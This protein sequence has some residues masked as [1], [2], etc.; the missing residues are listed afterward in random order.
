MT[1]IT[2]TYS[3]EDNKI[4]LYPASRLDAETYARVKAA[5]FSWAPKQNLFVAPK[6]TT[7]REDLALELAGEIEPEEMTIAER[8][9]AKA[10]RLDTLAE[11]RRRDASAFSRAADR[12]SERFY[13]GQ[14]ILVGHHSERSARRDQKRMHSAMDAAN[15]AQKAVGYWLYKASS[16]EQHANYKKKP[17][18]RARRIETLLAE[19]RDLQRDINRA[20]RALA[21]WEKC[22]TDEQ[23]RFALGRMDSRETCSGWDLYSAVDKGETTPADARLQCIATAERI[24]HGDIMRRWIEH[25]LNRLSFEREMLGPVPR[26]N[27]KLTPVILQAFART[28]G[29]EKPEACELADGLSW[30]ISSPVQLPLHIGTGSLVEMTGDEWRDLMQSTGYEVPTPVERRKSDKPA[31]APLINPTPEEAERLQAVW[32]LRA[33]AIFRKKGLPPKVAPVR[34]VT[35]AAYSNLSKGDY[36]PFKTVE[37]SADGRVIQERWQNMKLVKSGEP[38]ARI[39][40]RR[41]S[42]FYVAD[43]VAVIEDKPGKP[44]PIDLAGIEAEARAALVEQVAA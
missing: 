36:A 31:D 16:V 21:I 27:G 5:G 39:R 43:S 9:I 22:T 13:M 14:P 4:R 34:K 29:A 37:I 35:Q 40:V 26:F 7:E 12:L 41:A 3:P 24:I 11:K 33:E 30:S 15:K 28:H 32:N 1:D 38:V 23:I 44:L 10:E 17:E 25:T 6:W 2:A 8:A 18:V 19:L 20:H 42:D